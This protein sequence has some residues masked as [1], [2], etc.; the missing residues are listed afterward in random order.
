MQAAPPD[1]VDIQYYHLLK[2]LCPVDPPRESSPLSTHASQQ[3]CRALRL[4]CGSHN[5]RAFAED[6]VAQ[7]NQL[8]MGIP[9]LDK[10]D[11]EVVMALRQSLEHMLIQ[12][13]QDARLNSPLADALRSSVQ[14]RTPMRSAVAELKNELLPQWGRSNLAPMLELAPGRLPGSTK[15]RCK[16]PTQGQT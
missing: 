7:F 6:A 1:A 10:T 5:E 9:L 8:I 13:E 12:V 4:F 15:Q 3:L 11:I 2:A 14:S 16:Q